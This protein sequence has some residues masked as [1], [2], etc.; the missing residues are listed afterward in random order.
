MKFYL[1]LLFS[2]LFG[3]L[4]NAQNKQSKVTLSGYVKDA[5]TGES[6][7]GATIYCP[8]LQFG[9]AS[10]DY[11]FYSINLPKDSVT[12][13]FS[14]IGY[15]SIEKRLLLSQNFT[16][17]IDLRS[18]EL[19]EEVVVSADSYQ[20]QINTTQM[21]VD[22]ISMKEAKLLPALFGE[23]DI[24][25]TL[26]LK[27]GIKTGGEGTSGIVVRGGSPDQNL[28][29]LDEA[30]IYNPSHLFGFFSTF[31]SDAVKDV[32]LY[33]GGFPSK[34]GGRLSSVI[35]VKL[36][37]GNRKK[38]SGTGGVGLIASRL[39]LEGPIVKDKSSYMISG[40][41][42][43][44]DLITRRINKSKENDPEYNPIPDYYFYDFNAKVSYDLSEKDKLFFSSYYGR[45]FF[46]FS[47]NSLDV[48]FNWGNTAL[49][50]RWNRVF[51]PQL[52]ANTTLTFSDYNYQI[53]NRFG[54][55]ISFELS[56]GIRD[57]T[58][59][60]DFL[61]T[62][63][64]RHSI[65]FGANYTLHQFEVGRF[66]AA[67]DDNTF[68][69][70]KG[71][72]FTGSAMGIYL[73]DDI[74]INEQFKIN[75]GLRLS[76]FY[77]EE[78]YSLLEPRFALKYSINKKI[79]LKTSYTYMGQYIHLVT[80]SAASLPTDIWYPSNATVKPQRSNQV[81]AGISFSIANQYLVTNELYYKWSQN[82]IDFRDN[83]QLFVNDNL[84]EEFVF[85]KGWSYGNEIYIEK[86]SG[87]F[88]GWIGYTLSWAWR[89]FEDILDGENFHPRYDSRHDLSVV[90]IWE[91][92]KRWSITG[93]WVYST[94]SVTTLPYGRFS[95][96]NIPGSDPQ[97][98]IPIYG[99][100]NSYRLPP[101]H[102]MDIGAVCRFFPKWGEADLSF[103][104]YNAY[105]RR[106]PYFIY[107]ETKEDIEGNPTGFQAKQVSLFPIIPS[108]TFNFKF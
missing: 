40:R 64:N 26:Q 43:Y 62:P 11:G 66:Q 88:T 75:T 61:Y 100:R 102:R 7:I 76:G 17:N 69:F 22:K 41:R 103:S 33:K 65:S 99:D 2:I 24:I 85:G 58:A 30:T 93:T 82:Q 19:L 1:L 55:F 67:D 77:N 42:T 84:D 4:L 95:I 39:S 5:D 74:E 46:G 21:S 36:N 107:L 81:A 94:G 51:S 16:L 79:S 20:E 23:V 59:K 13:A 45:D 10:N 108:V 68:N 37:D 35:D 70:E 106:N 87:K 31:N 86:K 9:T 98:I 63:N 32:K 104:A 91:L 3:Q 97:L 89:Q 60:T 25:K 14:F 83:A 18:G 71:Q 80:N 90:A 96:Q 49:A 15:R 101:Y 53:K 28:F 29:I 57:Y 78:F 50:L 52:F 38:F 8:E 56:S 72:N 34:Y 92:N 12:I 27:P 48:N 47:G 6:L 44:A 105:N 54:D 73:S